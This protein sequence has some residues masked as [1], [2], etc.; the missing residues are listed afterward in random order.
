MKSPI[1]YACNLGL[2]I[3]GIIAFALYIM[4]ATGEAKVGLVGVMFVA[5]FFPVV[6]YQQLETQIMKSADETPSADDSSG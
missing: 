6:L 4:G 5:I 3:A 2:T 1:R